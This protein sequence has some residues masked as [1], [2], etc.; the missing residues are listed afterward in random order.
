MPSTT[1]EPQAI[2]AP[3]TSSAIFLTVTVRPDADIDDVRD[4]VAAVGDLVKNVGFRDAASWV[5][6]VVAIGADIW[7][8][9][10]G[11]PRPKHLRAFQEIRGEVHTA[12][13]TPGDLFFH[14]RAERHDLC[15]ELERQILDEFGNTVHVEDEVT[16]FRYF[17]ARDLLGFVDGTANPVGGQKATAA[18]VGA[19]DPDYAGGSYITVQKY[20]HR[21]DAWGRLTAEDQETIIGRTKLDNRELPDLTGPAQKSHKTLSTITDAEGVEHDILRN[22]MPFGSPAGKEFGTY[23]IGYAADLSVTEQ[24]LRRMFVGDPVGKHDRILDFSTAHTG[25][26]FYAPTVDF[27][28]SLAP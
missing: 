6:C 3:L 4:A 24:M 8:R 13:S 2:L 20:L 7:D 25:C 22:N 21:L 16:G 14:I 12:V 19:D 11:A 1:P 27:L 28:E 10:T 17:D 5:S 26:T 9:L 15:F 23:F 18:V